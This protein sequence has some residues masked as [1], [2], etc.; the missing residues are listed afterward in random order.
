VPPRYAVPPKPCRQACR[1]AVLATYADAR[2]LSVAAAMTPD[3]MMFTCR[4]AMPKTTVPP[5][6]MF[7][8]PGRRAMSHDFFF[9]LF[10]FHFSSLLIFVGNLLACFCCCFFARLSLLSVTTHA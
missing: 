1:K 10:C 6:S 5:L 7:S 3:A 9:L 8:R 4:C 2:C